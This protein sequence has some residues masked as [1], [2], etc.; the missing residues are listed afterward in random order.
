MSSHP[1]G[2]VHEPEDAAGPSFK[3]TPDVLEARK[4]LTLFL[5]SLVIFPDNGRPSHTRLCL[6]KDAVEVKSIPKEVVGLRRQY[7]KEVQANIAARRRYQELVEQ[8]ATS[9]NI[10]KGIDEDCG[11]V[12]KLQTHLRL[13]KLRKRHQELRITK[14]YFEKFQATNPAASGCLQPGRSPV[15]ENAHVGTVYQARKAH[16]ESS[17][18]PGEDTKA[19][20]RKLEMAV[21]QM[22]HQLG[23]EKSL[24]AEAKARY[25]GS[26]SGSDRSDIA[27]PA[28]K[29]E[30]HLSAPSQSV[31]P[32]IRE[33]LL[34]LLQQQ[35]TTIM[36][37]A[38]LSEALNM[39]TTSTLENL[40]RLAD[41]SHLLPSHPVMAPQ[42]RFRHAAAALGPTK[43]GQKYSCTTGDQDDIC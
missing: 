20:L 25:R 6:P 26:L 42:E 15:D 9:K 13:L 21:L 37:N 14:H 2:N 23:Q 12:E 38:F 36:H 33:Q 4:I 11:G 17:P 28:R 19:L 31:L 18:S 3:R 27:E 16:A 39:E 40:E 34:P 30:P 5:A 32:F 41:E 1:H 35:K 10:A 24:L 22:K 8:T 43:L 29:A 7:L